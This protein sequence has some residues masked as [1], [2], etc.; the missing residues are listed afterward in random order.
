MPEYPGQS[1]YS[2]RGKK[3]A[4]GLAVVLALTL[5]AWW[6]IKSYPSAVS[7]L[8]GDSPAPENQVYLPGVLN[9]LSGIVVKRDARSIVIRVRI[10]ESADG[11]KFYTEESA[12]RWTDK[13]S[14]AKSDGYPSD[15]IPKQA[16]SASDVK[17]GDSVVVTASE[18]IRD[19]Q[20]FT[21][22]SIV[23][24]EEWSGNP[25]GVQPGYGPVGG[26]ITAINGTTLS[27]TI[28]TPQALGDLAAAAQP[29]LLAPGAWT[30]KLTDAAVVNRVE[31]VKPK[32]SSTNPPLPPKA[33]LAKLADLKVGAVVRVFIATKDDAQ[34]QITSNRVDIADVMGP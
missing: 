14:F 21:A 3:I 9:S 26:Q 10:P 34:R 19:A 32:G 12:V 25:I 16:I 11:S 15:E 29:P 27:M 18:N 1:E 17:L 20:S 2:S 5:A 31:Y 22:T 7:P 6:F 4:A 28:Q 33:F 23:D 13:T 24:Y 8:S 30:V